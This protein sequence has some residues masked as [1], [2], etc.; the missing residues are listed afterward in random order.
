MIDLLIH[1]QDI[2]IKISL[3]IMKIIYD[4]LRQFSLQIFY[5]YWFLRSRRLDFSN[6]F[7]Y[8]CNGL[9]SVKSL[10]NTFIIISFSQFGKNISI[11]IPHFVPLFC[12]SVLD[13]LFRLISI[14]FWWGK[15]FR[16]RS[17]N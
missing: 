10:S 13:S 16:A 3:F 6:H 17:V 1:C 2:V 7:H 9:N 4:L 11:T 15:F 5:Y 12:L 14:F 8:F